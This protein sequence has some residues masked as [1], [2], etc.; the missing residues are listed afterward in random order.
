MV[1]S[2]TRPDTN[3]LRTVSNFRKDD[4]QEDPRHEQSHPRGTVAVT[5][6]AEGTTGATSSG[7]Q[8]RVQEGMAFWLGSP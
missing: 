6:Q 3:T 2:E 1:L 7:T 8:G 5:R 4:E